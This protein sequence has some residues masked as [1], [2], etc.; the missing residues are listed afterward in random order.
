VESGSVRQGG[1]SHC[2]LVR[3]WDRL[4]IFEGL[5]GHDGGGDRCAGVFDAVTKS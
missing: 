3:R 2:G 5:S 4:S 1:G